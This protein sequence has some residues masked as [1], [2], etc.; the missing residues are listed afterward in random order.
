VELTW[1]WMPL[2]LAAVIGVGIAIRLLV[3]R[4]RAHKGDRD[5]AAAA[6]L[7]RITGLPRYRAAYRRGVILF[8]ALLVVSL[9]SLGGLAV[10]AARPVST[11]VRSTDSASRDIVLCLDVSGSMLPSDA[12][13]LET[14]RDI[15]K[16]FD[17]ER[18]S[19]VIW[20]ASAVQVFPLTDDY[21]YVDDQLSRAADAARAG[22]YS[23][24]FD[25]LNGTLVGDGSASSLVGD[26]LAS[27]VLRFDNQDSTRSRTIV[28]AT[29][30][31]TRGQGIVTVDEAVAF[32]KERKVRVYA[33]SPT[34][35][36]SKSSYVRELE[37]EVKRTGGRLFGL[38]ESSAADAIVAEVLKDQ[39]Q[40]LEG[41]PQIVVTDHPGVPLVI[42]ILGFWVV[43]FVGWRMRA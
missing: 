7:A 36:G 12:K 33:I 6:N 39:A 19:L 13:V 15:V 42:G 34:T 8:G 5:V 25:L 24:E 17:G 18:I 1:A 2:L 10:A 9:V 32:A 22:G 16:G 27:C 21:S 41:A 43:A 14:F 20:N 37:T 23:S 30:N 38:D 40:H 26:G 3:T 4:G 29:D 11:T 31:E 28:L 35:F